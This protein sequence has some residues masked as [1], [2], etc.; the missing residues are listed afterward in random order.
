MAGTLQFGMELSIQKCLFVIYYYHALQ[1]LI[2][3]CNEQGTLYTNTKRVCFGLSATFRDTIKYVR[4][5]SQLS[6]SVNVRQG[7]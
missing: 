1:L 3:Q 4:R 6:R 2:K 7:T 5:S